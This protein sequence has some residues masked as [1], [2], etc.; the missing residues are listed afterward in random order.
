MHPCTHAFYTIPGNQEMA[1]KYQIFIGTSHAEPMLRNN[2]DEWD[3]DQYGE[4]DYSIN[5][6]VVKK[7]WKG[8]IEELTNNDKYIVTLGMRGVHDSGMRG[9]LTKE[10]KVQMLETIISDQRGMLH[11]V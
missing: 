10:G 11:V 5:A 3:H 2:V 7:Y 8:R 6:D 4:Y 9:N 1:A